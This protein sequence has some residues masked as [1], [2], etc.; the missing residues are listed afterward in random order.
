MNES[1][2]HWAIALVNRHSEKAVACTVTMNDRPLKGRWNEPGA[3]Q[4][5]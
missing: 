4:K 3:A 1:A 2:K 5:Q